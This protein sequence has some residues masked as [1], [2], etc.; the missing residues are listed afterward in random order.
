MTFDRTLHKLITQLDELTEEQIETI[1]T[2]QTTSRHRLGASYVKAFDSGRRILVTGGHGAEM[3]AADDAARSAR[4]D[5]PPD[6]RMAFRWKVMA[7]AF[8][9]SLSEAQYEALTNAWDAATAR[10]PAA[11]S[12][13]PAVA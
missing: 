10:R 2:A 4:H 11:R 6:V 1:R 5:L 8:P 9:E 3:A 7:T 12:K 13:R